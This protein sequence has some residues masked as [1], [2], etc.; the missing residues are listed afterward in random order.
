[1]KR[2]IDTL[3]NMSFD[4]PEGWAL[5]EDTYNLQ[6]GQGF[7]NKENYL[8]D[9]KVISFFE[10]HRDPDEFLESYTSLTEKY[11]SISDRFELENQFSLKANGF[12]FPTYVIKG[13][14]NKLIYLVQVFIN[15]GDCLGCFM[16]YIDK[17]DSD[18]KKMI[19]DNP[20][21]G[22]LV[23]ILRTIE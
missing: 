5:T 16:I 23:K 7:I 14:H 4:L 20:L 3:N 19:K 10:V 8:K 15:C 9:G 22:D 1:M 17:Y 11:K 12:N 2:V 6:N 13:Y 18:V 21:F